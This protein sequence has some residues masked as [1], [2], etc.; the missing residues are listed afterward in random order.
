[1]GVVKDSKY[2]SVDEDPIPMAYYPYT[3][4]GGISHLE[5]EVR[6]SGAAALSSV[7]GAV[8]AMDPN[9]PLEN[10]MAQQAVFEQSY[11]QPT[12]V[13]RLSAF[14]G[15][16]AA[17]LVAVGLYGTLA[18]GWRAARLRSASGWRSAPSAS[19]F[20]HADSRELCRLR[21]LDSHSDF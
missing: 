14:F 7:A 11:S 19:R 9:L 15:L 17:L 2:T 1:M 4:R 5:V 12:D 18:Y 8:R 3:Q 21:W 20:W 6:T 13:F 16:L 10:P